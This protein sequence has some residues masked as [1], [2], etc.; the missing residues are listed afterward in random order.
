MTVAIRFRSDMSSACHETDA[1]SRTHASR[2]SIIILPRSAP[3]RGLIGGSPADPPLPPPAFP[4][5]ASILAPLNTC[6]FSGPDMDRGDR[7]SPEDAS[8]LPVEGA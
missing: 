2:P 5:P 6:A 1:P 8:R 4:D 7:I 3:R